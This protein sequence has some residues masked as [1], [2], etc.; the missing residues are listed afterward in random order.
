MKKNKNVKN[1]RS[2][3]IDGW[4]IGGT[5]TAIFL[6]GSYS[7]GWGDFICIVGWSLLNIFGM[8]YLIHKQ[9]KIERVWK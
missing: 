1:K 9:K 6:W 3:W 2:L 7:K 4:L 8:I 5:T